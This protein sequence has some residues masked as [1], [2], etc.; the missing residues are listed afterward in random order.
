MSGQVIVPDPPAWEVEYQ[1]WKA[2]RS[3]DKQLP[4]EFEHF[5][6]A[7]G[8]QRGTGGWEPAPRIT[9]ADKSNDRRSLRRRLET[10]LFLLIK[11]EGRR[12]HFKR[13][14]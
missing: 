4:E 6:K 12:L 5:Q 1:E 9:A 11:M 8:G 13:L 10:R 3:R 2:S 7:A 14:L